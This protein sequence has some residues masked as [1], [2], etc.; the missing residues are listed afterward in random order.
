CGKGI[1]RSVQ[2]QREIQV[3]TGEFWGLEPD[4][5]VKAPEGLYFNYQHALMET[6]V[7]PESYFDI[8]YS[9][10][11]ME[12]VENPAP[13]LTAVARCLKPGGVYLFLTPNEE[14]LV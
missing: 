1:G 13:F 9:S 14:S 11:V 4:E 7:L 10:M 3:K 5:S 12:H 8:A 2:L 6:A